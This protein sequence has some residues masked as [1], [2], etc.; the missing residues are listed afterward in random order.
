MERNQRDIILRLV[1]TSHGWGRS[2]FP[3]SAAE[4]VGTRETGSSR[5]AIELFDRGGWD[6][7]I[8]DTHRR[9]GPWACAYYEALL[10]AADCAVSKEGS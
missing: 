9:I 2:Y 1:G 7:L 10:R 3:H 6:E 5:A 4:L 8:E